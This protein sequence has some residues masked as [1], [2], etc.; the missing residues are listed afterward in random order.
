[1]SASVLRMADWSLVS[2]ADY[3]LWVAG[4][5]DN[6]DSW[7]I[8]NFP[9]SIRPWNFYALWQYTSSGGRLDRDIFSGTRE[10]WDKYANPSGAP[11]PAPAPSLAKKSNEDLATEVI[12]GLWGN[13]QERKNRLEAA[14]YNYYAVQQIVNDRLAPARRDTA[15]YY[16]VKPGD[17]LWAIAQRYGT[18]YQEI[19]RLSGISNPS[20]IFPGQKVRVK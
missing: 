11:A 12:R 4:Y 6:R 9:Y 20:L 15:E 14:G 13:G 1:M 3:G 7:D 17:T 18:T 8:P 2:N 5:P 19:A 10:A 16:I